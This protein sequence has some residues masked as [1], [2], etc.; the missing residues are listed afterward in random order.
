M[1]SNQ[2]IDTQNKDNRDN[3]ANT[4][5]NKNNKTIYGD[6][7]FNVNYSDNKLDIKSN[8]FRLKNVDNLFDIVGSLLQINL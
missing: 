5:N 6:L 4:D 7:V 3:G 1:K 2:L 8:F